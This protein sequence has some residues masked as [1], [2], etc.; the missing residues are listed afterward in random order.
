MHRVETISLKTKT[1]DTCRN[2]VTVTR[3]TQGIILN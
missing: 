1:L 3:Q 2:R